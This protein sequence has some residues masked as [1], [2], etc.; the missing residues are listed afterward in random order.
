MSKAHSVSTDI[1][2]IEISAVG[3]K[4]KDSDRIQP[5][6]RGRR[7]SSR[8]SPSALPG[9]IAERALP[10]TSACRKAGKQSVDR[11]FEWYSADGADKRTTIADIP[12]DQA[13]ASK[14][15]SFA[16]EARYIR[17]A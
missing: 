17:G 2:T 15:E 12:T 14:L 10:S 11:A 13:P 7:V 4:R 8:D 6:E 1:R 9:E 16:P 3:R 5:P